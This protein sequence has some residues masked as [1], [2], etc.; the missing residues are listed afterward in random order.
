MKLILY[1]NFGNTQLLINNALSNQI[2]I[3]SG[4]KQGNLLSLTLFI[5]YIQLFLSMLRQHKVDS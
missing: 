2:P 3:Q 1:I 5:L 4:V